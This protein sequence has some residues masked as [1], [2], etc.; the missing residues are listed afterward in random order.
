VTLGSL[1]AAR[2]SGFHL[3]FIAAA[4]LL[5]AAW[6]VAALQLRTRWLDEPKRMQVPPGLAARAVGCAQCAPVAATS[7]SGGQGRASA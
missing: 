7:T 6:T 3:A 2:V 5:G 4:V 1:H